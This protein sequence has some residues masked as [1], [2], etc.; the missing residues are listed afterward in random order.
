MGT[1][2]VSGR[3]DE[4]KLEYAEAI[5]REQLGISFGQYCS[6]VVVDY[7][8]ATGTLPVVE[9]V[10]S[11]QEAFKKLIE[12]SDEPGNRAIGAMSDDEI[13]DLIASR[14]DESAAARHE[15]IA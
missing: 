10:D 5:T 7:I 1:K 9:M 15:H 14:Y 2:I 13:R 8:C 3:V 6:S 11:Y 4:Q 12:L